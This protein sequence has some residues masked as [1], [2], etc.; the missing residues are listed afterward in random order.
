MGLL[1]RLRD[2]QPVSLEER[3]PQTGLK[4]KDLLVLE[5]PVRAGADVH[6]PRHVRH[7]LYF[8]DRAQAAAAAAEARAR[9]FAPEW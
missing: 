8:P 7:F 6:A 9:G 4:F 3:S 2:R 5:Q 1:S